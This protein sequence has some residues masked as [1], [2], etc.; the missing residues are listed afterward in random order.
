[1]ARHLLTYPIVRM[2]C[3]RILSHLS[4]PLGLEVH[5]SY[6]LFLRFRRLGVLASDYLQLLHTPLY[7]PIQL[8]GSGLLRNDRNLYQIYLSLG[9]RYVLLYQSYFNTGN[10]VM[11]LYYSVYYQ[12]Y[13]NLLISKLKQ[14]RDTHL[15][16]RERSR[17]QQSRPAVAYESECDLA[18]NAGCLS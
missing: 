8:I 18:L 10:S 7:H 12:L 3:F 9:I 6:W 15:Y 16:K 5:P 2:T 17:F 13:L 11:V 4:N 14:S 1:M